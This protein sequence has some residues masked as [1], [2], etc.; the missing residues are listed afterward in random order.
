MDYQT[1]SSQHAFGG[2]LSTASAA[3]LAQPT[4]H[5]PQ[6]QQ[7]YADPHAR[8][9]QSTPSPFPYAQQF[10]PNGQAGAYVGGVAPAAAVMQPGLSH[11]QNQLHQARG[12]P[13]EAACPPP[14]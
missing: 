1:F 9:Q 14:S 4:T 3:H 2:P 8:L 13:G 7:L 10:T 6:H 11:N 5:S 12:K